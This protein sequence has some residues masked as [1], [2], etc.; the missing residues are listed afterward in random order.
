[1]LNTSNFSMELFII[2]TI[3]FLMYNRNQLDFSQ[4]DH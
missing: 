1:M 4:K 3:L 2:S